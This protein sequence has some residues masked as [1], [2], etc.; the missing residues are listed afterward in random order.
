MKFSNKVYD[1][2]MFTAQIVLPGLGTLYAALS[3]IWGLPATESVLGTIAAVD[4]ALGAILKGASAGYTP[5]TA[6]HIAVDDSGPN[7]IYQIQLKGEPEA[8]LDGKKNITL[9]I[10]PGDIQPVSS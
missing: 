5:E 4:T 9:S 8:V 10:G 6:G 1:V 3:G 7:K 2:L